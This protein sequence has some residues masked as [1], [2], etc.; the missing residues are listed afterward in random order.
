VIRVNRYTVSVAIVAL[1]A[2]VLVAITVT[3]GS[4]DAGQLVSG[5]AVAQAA[6]ATE[7]V[8]GANVSTRVQMTVDGLD[9]PI[10][11]RLDGISD[12]RGHST[13]MVGTYKNMPAQVPGRGADGTIPLEVI[14]LAPD[15]YMKSPVFSASLPDGKSWLHIDIAKSSKKLGLS[16]P[17]QLNQSDP[18]QA[19]SNLRAMSD[20]VERLGSEHVRGVPT[21]HYRGKVLLRR[22]PNAVPASQRAA[23]RATSKRLIEL[24]GTESYPLE[25]WIDRHHLVRRLRIQMKMNLPPQNQN[26]TMDMTTEMFDFGPKQK[27]KAPP[28]AE[29]IDVTKLAGAGGQTP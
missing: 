25:V 15:V 17:T 12:T 20:R 28:A 24:T 5:S 23:A 6:S 2:A 29:T 18:T 26:M 11:M 8:P 14:T 19:L 9:R 16:D 21:T 13:R 10:E 7:K 22:L 3:G 27:A 1:C 4:G